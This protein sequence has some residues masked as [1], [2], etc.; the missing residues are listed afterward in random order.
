MAL[1]LIEAAKL[2][3]G[4]VIRSSVI[5]IFA[6][7]S[8]LLR[9]L[10]FKDIAGNALRYNRE[11][12][13]PGIG[14]RGVNE[15]FS[16]SV[17]ILNPLVEPL[18]I[19]GGDLDVD[20]FI[21]DTMGADQR[22]TQEAMKVKKL[23]SVIHQKFIKGDSETAPKE[24][25]GL[26]KRLGGNQLVDN[27]GAG[28]SLFTLNTAILRVDN[29]THLLMTKN[30]RLRI[31]QAANNTG[32]GGF[33]THS[34]DEFGR[35]ITSYRGLPMLDADEN[36]IADAAINETEEVGSNRTSIYILSLGDGQ[37]QGMQNGV[38]DVRDMGELESKPA[39]RTRVEWYVGLLL[40]HPRA[41]ARLRNIN[42]ATAA[43]A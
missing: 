27:G 4:D 41:A 18:V 5:E 8:S 3:S 32:V 35:P 15:G 24:Y 31:E 36:D 10:P 6:R 29:P 22:S 26:Q 17:G 21:V 9:V 1:T 38:M 13:L 30:V 42:G 7:S 20:K 40:E 25:D 34:R 12:T 16:E 23:A 19:A 39:L 43:V 14:F 37:L 33:V 2:H 28:L 11:D